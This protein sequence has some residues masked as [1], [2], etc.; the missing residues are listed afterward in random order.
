MYSD[1][2]VDRSIQWAGNDFVEHSHYT[3][4]T[5]TMAISD[6][7]TALPA[8]PTG[9]RPER[10]LSAYIVAEGKT[11]DVRPYEELV[12]L[13]DQ[14]AGEG[15]PTKIAFTT[16]TTGV[17]YPIPDAAY[18]LAVRFWE[19]FTDWTAGGTPSPNS[20]NLPDD[21]LRVVLM[22][23]AVARLQANEPEHGYAAER[24]AE[25]IAYRTRMTQVGKLGVRV[26]DR[27][28]LEF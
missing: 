23:G 22:T 18:T 16:L 19:P 14:E 10:L 8:F 6:G 26:N 28:M 7:S 15:V 4:T 25:Y 5:S 11:L 17:V 24:M 27:D 2:D 21:V 9:F 12:E 20:F 3:K 1:A 13:I